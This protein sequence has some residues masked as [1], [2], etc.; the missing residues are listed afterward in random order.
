MGDVYDEAEA[1][2]I[3]PQKKMPFGTLCRPFLDMHPDI[4]KNW[5]KENDYPWIEDPSN[6]D[7]NFE[8]VRWRKSYSLFQKHG[9]SL[10]S[11]SRSSH[12]LGEAYNY[13]REEVEKAMLSVFQDPALDTFRFKSMPIYLA[14]CTLQ[15]IL[16]N[17]SQKKYPASWLQI[18]RIFERIDFPQTG[19][20]C[21]LFPKK[22]HIIIRKDS[23]TI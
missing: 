22:K 2:S 13:L 21:V 18:T 16:Q 14:K 12:H 17:V 23:R 11:V 3:S 9:L 1:S 4:F 10:E 20:G 19:G 5:L 7:D 8:R 6:E 15:G